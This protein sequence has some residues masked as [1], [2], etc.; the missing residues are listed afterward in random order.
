MT[1]SPA[2]I[3]KTNFA[4]D[5]RGYY[6]HKLLATQVAQWISP[7]FAIRISQMYDDYATKKYEYEINNKDSKLCELQIIIEDNR[8]EAKRAED[9]YQDLVKRGIANEKK[10]EDR[11]Q[12]LVDRG[13]KYTTMLQKNINEFKD[14]NISIKQRSDIIIEEMMKLSSKND[15]IKIL[16][17]SLRNQ[18]DLL[19]ISTISKNTRKFD[20]INKPS[21]KYT[22]TFLII[23]MVKV[24][25]PERN[26]HYIVNRV[27]YRS[28]KFGVN[29]SIKQILKKYEDPIYDSYHIYMETSA[30]AITAWNK[31]KSDK[32]IKTNGSEIIL[33]Q[34]D[35]YKLIEKLKLIIIE[36]EEEL[37]IIQEEYER[38]KNGNDEEKEFLKEFEDSD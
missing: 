16:L 2:L 18:V 28:I 8:T 1:R 14:Q 13:Y 38:L 31:L 27:Q 17:L 12:D 19:P 30:N 15:K 9:R 29:N 26:I 21:N 3:H 24:F 20:I 25:K 34:T 10:A 36:P 22:Q 11:Y 5:Y 7:S 37:R 32:L 23:T 35:I 4:I 33:N 6:V